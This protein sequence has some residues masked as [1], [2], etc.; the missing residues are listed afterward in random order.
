MSGSIDVCDACDVGRGFEHGH[1]VETRM[2]QHLL[3]VRAAQSSGTVLGMQLQQGLE[4]SRLVGHVY[5]SVC[6]CVWVE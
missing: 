6:G 5:P 4:R 1:G 3:D 2:L